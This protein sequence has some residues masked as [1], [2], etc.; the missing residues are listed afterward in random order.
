MDRK[1][2][3]E[4]YQ[5]TVKIINE[6]EYDNSNGNTVIIEREK[7]MVSGTKF[8]YSKINIDYN[9]LARYKD[10]IVQVVNNDCL[11]EAKRLVDMGMKPAVLNM[12]SFSMPSGGVINGSSAQEEEIFRRTNLFKSLYQFHNIGEKF[13]V[14]QRKERYPLDYNYGGI[15]TPSV[16]VFKGGRDVNY[17]LLDKPF[18]IDVISV[19]AVKNP[20]VEHGKI[21]PFVK[22][23]LINKVKHILNMA[24]VNGNDSLVL[25]A[26]GC[27]AYKTPPT[28]MADIMFKVICS[29]DFKDAFKAIKIAII[30]VPS[31]IKEHNPN[32]NFK[33]FY[34]TFNIK[35]SDE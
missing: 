35:K 32:G 1:R 3:I 29:N 10:A 20:L 30:E 6:K 22:K 11:Y 12:A 23:T 34:D 25:S 8:Y 15:Y 28:E 5:G 9:K 27:G 14:E 19:A 24:L 13:G 33:P 17:P 4:V 16:T 31:T 18:M 7:E 26:F 21:V 2:L